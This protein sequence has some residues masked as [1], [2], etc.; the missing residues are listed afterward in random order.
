M[1]GHMNVKFKVLTKVLLKIQVTWDVTL[2]RL[3]NRHRRL[4]GKAM[5]LSS[6][7]KADNYSPFDKA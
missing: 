5:S 7:T 2:F 1:H 6:E 4:E 3:V